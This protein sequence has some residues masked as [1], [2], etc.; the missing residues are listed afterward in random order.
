MSSSP[1]NILLL[2]AAKLNASALG[3]WWFKVTRRPRTQAT[4]STKG[5]H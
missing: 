2:M 3:P 4:R 1:L 5:I